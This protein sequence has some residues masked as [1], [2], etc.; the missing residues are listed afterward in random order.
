MQQELLAL[1][2][3]Y[4][5]GLPSPLPP[6]ELQYADYTIWQRA[7]LQGDPV[8]RNSISGRES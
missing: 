8:A 3:A 5:Q 6:L 1:Y 2:T 4:C 7:W